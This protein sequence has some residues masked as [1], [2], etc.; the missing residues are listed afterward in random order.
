MNIYIIYVHMD[1]LL[2]AAF[3]AEKRASQ[4]SPAKGCKCPIKRFGK[5]TT[6]KELEKEHQNE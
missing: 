3:S 4:L 1:Q 6:A 5:S 2:E